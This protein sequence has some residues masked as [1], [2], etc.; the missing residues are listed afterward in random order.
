M[1]GTLGIAGAGGAGAGSAT[2]GALRANAAPSAPAL[3]IMLVANSFP[4]KCMSLP[5]RWRHVCHRSYGVTEVTQVTR[6]AFTQPLWGRRHTVT[7]SVVSG[8]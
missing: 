4:V 6:V 1:P 8:E 7:G 3:A 2:A 5:I